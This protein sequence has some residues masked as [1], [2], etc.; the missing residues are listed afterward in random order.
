MVQLVKMLGQQNRT[1]YIY[2]IRKDKLNSLKNQNMTQLETLKLEV[3]AL[4]EKINSAMAVNEDSVTLT[5]EQLRDFAQV[6]SEDII[7]KVKEAIEDVNID[8]EDHVSLEL[9]R[10]E[11]EVNVDRSDVLAEIVSSMDDPDDVTD[12]DVVRYLDILKK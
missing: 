8:I 1:T 10:F 4:A 9:N 3:D 6:I 5:R 12:E 7:F 11:L 2:S